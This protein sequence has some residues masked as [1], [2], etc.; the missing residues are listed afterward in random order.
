MTEMTKNELAAFETEARGM[1]LDTAKWERLGIWDV[2]VDE[3]KKPEAKKEDKKVDEAKVE[4]ALEC[5]L[6]GTH[7]NEAIS[8][9]R[10]MEH[11]AQMAEILSEDEDES[12]E[13]T[14][15]ELRAELEALEP[16]ELD[17]LLAELESDETEEDESEE[18]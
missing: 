18:N 7:L 12:E 10:L 5:P 17:A 6:C 11:T 1:I 16:E 3:S 9:E 15:D 13:M 8:D 14:E 2:K 4:E